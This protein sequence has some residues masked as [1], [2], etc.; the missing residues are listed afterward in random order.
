[1]R[2]YRYENGNQRLV[3]RRQR[4][5]AQRIAPRTVALGYVQDFGP[6]SYGSPALVGGVLT[7]E[8]DTTDSGFKWGAVATGVM[9]GIGIWFATALL[10]RLF[11][12]LKK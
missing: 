3:M 8:D 7:A 1:M 10:D 4:K 11:P 2:F 12:K 5:A 6:I 9:T